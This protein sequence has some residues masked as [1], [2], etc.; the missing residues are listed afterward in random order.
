M[1]L[2]VFC[3]RH[4]HPVS[5]QTNKKC[6]LRFI[7]NNMLLFLLF[8]LNSRQQLDSR[9]VPAL[10]CIATSDQT[11][12]RPFEFTAELSCFIGG[13]PDKLLVVPIIVCKVK[14]NR[15]RMQNC[16]RIAFESRSCFLKKSVQIMD[17]G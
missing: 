7:P 3:S 17:L 16:P 8:V 12:L 4:P 1:N 9:L 15:E 2:L 10:C 13:K 6:S 5:S 14:S 11:L